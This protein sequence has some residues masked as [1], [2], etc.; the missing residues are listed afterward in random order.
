MAYQNLFTNGHLALECR[1][2]VLDQTWSDETDVV[3][4]DHIHA[5]ANATCRRK[6]VAV[7]AAGVFVSLGVLVLLC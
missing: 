5:G 4:L 6:T 3:L 7:V 2:S 1:V